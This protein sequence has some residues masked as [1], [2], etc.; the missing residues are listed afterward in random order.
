MTTIGIIRDRGQLTIPESVRKVARWTGTSS[1]VS[2]SVESPQ[3]II[4]T[5]H[6]AV[7]EAE[8]EKLFELI[9]K[10]RAI[11]GRGSVSASEFIAKG[12][13]SH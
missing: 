10:S 11:K 7:K 4:I 12:R 9:K 5:P 2:F 6:Q 1:V 3:E 8:W 13:R